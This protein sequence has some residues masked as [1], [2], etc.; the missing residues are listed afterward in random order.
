M[1]RLVFAGSLTQE[2]LTFSG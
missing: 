1:P 2:T